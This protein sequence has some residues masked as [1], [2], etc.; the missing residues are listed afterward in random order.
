MFR[1]YV[2]MLLLLAAMPLFG[3]ITVFNGANITITT[4]ALVHCN[5]GVKITNST[6]LTNNGTLNVTKNS[7]LALAGNFENSSSSVVNGNGIYTIEQDWVNSATFQAQGSEVVLNG[8]TEQLIT[9]TNG[10][11]T[12]FNDLTLTGAGTGTNQRKSLVGVNSR[13]SVNGI[14]NLN[15]RELYTGTQSFEVLNVAPT[16]VLQSATFGSEGFVSSLDPGYFVRHTNQA[17]SYLFPVGSSDGVYRYRPIELTPNSA[18]NATYNVRF[19]NYSADA[20]GYF[21]AQH[22]ADIDAANDLF[23]HSIVRSSGSANVDIRTHYLTSDDGEWIS[24][25]HWYTNNAQW[26][27]VTTTS[28]GSAGNFAYNEK[29][30]WNFPTSNP[31]YVL[32]NTANELI[33]PNVFTPNEDGAND[34][35]FII[36]K[37]LTD[38][39][40]VIVNRWGNPVFETTDPAAVWDGTSG[41]NPCNE[42]TYFYILKA[43]SSGKDKVMQGH[44][45]LHRN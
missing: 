11:I 6:N 8:N 15:D 23:Y 45:T 10:T 13:T 17:T 21:L 31:S 41:G 24:Q 36:S 7:S 29:A 9:S 44:I 37:G 19:N 28:N 35:F 4:G 38:Y 14:L 39:N 1:H 27:N 26:E 3:Q 20:D 22:A 32:I 30:N 16:A 18:S 25:A 43:K 40:L 33:I 12:E 42:G 2:A 5:G 34:D